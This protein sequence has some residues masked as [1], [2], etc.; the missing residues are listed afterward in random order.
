MLITSTKINGKQRGLSTVDRTT[1]T[2]FICGQEL[3]SHRHIDRQDLTA[4]PKQQLHLR[5]RRHL[6]AEAGVSGSHVVDLSELNFNRVRHH[7]RGGD[8]HRYRRRLTGLCNVERA[9]DGCIPDDVSI[10]QT[11]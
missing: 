2:L 5:R 9:E 10:G 8:V 6:V 4:S 3:A 7:N 1:C 11:D